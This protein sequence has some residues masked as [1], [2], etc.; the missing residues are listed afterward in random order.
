MQELTPTSL[1]DVTSGVIGTGKKV[2]TIESEREALVGLLGQKGELDS[3]WA[4][5]LFPDLKEANDYSQALGELLN[6][7]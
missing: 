5:Y 4:K 2:P 1:T 3:K 6:N 7:Y